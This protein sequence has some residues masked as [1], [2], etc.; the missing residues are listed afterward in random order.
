MGADD[1]GACIGTEVEVGAD[2]GGGYWADRV[3]NGDASGVVEEIASSAHKLLCKKL[4]K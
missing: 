3:A 2:A 4:Q 1:G